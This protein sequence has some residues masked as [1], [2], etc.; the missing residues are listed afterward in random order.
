VARQGSHSPEQWYCR[1]PSFL[2]P[3]VQAFII[4]ACQY[5]YSATLLIVAQDAEVPCLICPNGARDDYAPYTSKD[6]ITCK[7]KEIIDNAKLF[8]TGSLWCSRYEV[9]AMPECCPTPP[10]TSTCNLCPNI[11]VSDNYEPYNNGDTCLVLL[12][13][14]ARSGFHA[15]YASCTVGWGAHIES[16]CCPT[17]ANNPCIICP[18]GATIL[19][20]TIGIRELVRI[21][22]RR[23][24]KKSRLTT[25]WS[26][27]TSLLNTPAGCC[28]PTCTR[29]PRALR[30]K[31]DVS[32]TVILF[33]K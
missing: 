13:Y 21:S 22:L 15:K 11:T 1:R 5:Y 4:I 14:Y 18:D 19:F 7:G 32:L 3:I 31:E 25:R 16:H 9:Q 6:P 17:E 10:T 20:L 24:W 12:D 26:R 8:E 29:S 30:S 27:L 23:C 33:K 2:P 28:L